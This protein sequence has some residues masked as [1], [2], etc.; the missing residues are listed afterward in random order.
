MAGIEPA[1]LFFW[2]VCDQTL[3][4]LGIDDIVGVVSVVS[5]YPLL[6]TRGKLGGTTKGTSIASVTFRKIL[7]VDI[8][9]RLPTITGKTLRTL[10]IT[11]TNNLG[12]FVGR[13]VPILGWL[14]LAADVVTIIYKS[15][16][17]YNGMVKP[18]DKVF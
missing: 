14:I 2:I 4:E 13:S 9:P 15:V 16:Q 17:K 12:A 7:N 11:M 1:E 5:G 10:K 3:E 18:E 8:K 6:S